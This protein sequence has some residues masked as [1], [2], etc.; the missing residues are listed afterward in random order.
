MCTPNSSNSPSDVINVTQDI[1]STV[2]D[3][4]HTSSSTPEIICKK[5]TFTIYFDVARSLVRWWRN[6]FSAVS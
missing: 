2:H 4:G 6:D 1:C 5:K 3:N